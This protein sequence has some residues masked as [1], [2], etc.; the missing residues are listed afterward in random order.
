ME[1]YRTETA[2]FEMFEFTID[3]QDAG[4]IAADPVDF[5]RKLL[6]SWAFP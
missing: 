5:F 1:K 4:L 2:T 3:E 6:E